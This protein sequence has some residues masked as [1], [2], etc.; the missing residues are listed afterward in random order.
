[1]LVFILLTILSFLNNGI[2]ADYSVERYPLIP[3]PAELVARD[4]F[5]IITPA[6][7]INS[8]IL[9]GETCK[10]VYYLASILSGSLGRPCFLNRGGSS[11]TGNINIVIDNKINIGNEGYELNITPEA[12]KI[13]AQDTAGAFY[14]IQTLRQLLPASIE[15]CMPL[16]K[17]ILK[18]PCGNIKDS[19]RFKYRGLMLDTARH[20]FSV[21]FIKK[22]IDV[23]AAYKFNTF[24]WH[25][26]DD[27]GWRIEIKRYPLLQSI[28]AF[29]KQTIVGHGRYNYPYM[30]D[31][32]RYGGYYSQEEIKEIVAFA[33]ERY[34]TVIPEI[35]FPGHCSAA[36]AAYP[37]IGC[38][39][40]QYET[41][42]RWGIF[43][44]TYCAGNEETFQFAENLLREVMQLFPSTLI[45]IGGDEV[46]K[47]C[48]KNCSL[49]QKRIQQEGLTGEEQLKSYFIKRIEKFLNANGRT[50]IGWDEILEGGLASNATVMSWR[51][52][53]GGIKAANLGHTVIMTPMEYA[54]FDFYQ[55]KETTEPLAIGGYV[56]LSKVYEFEPIPTELSSENVHYILGVQAN[57]WT[58]YI[59]TSEH[60]CYMAFPRACALAEVAWSMPERKSYDFFKRRLQ[61]NLEHL[62]AL[63]INYASY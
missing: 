45:H 27:Q 21:E 49:C 31:R 15:K 36:L 6:T 47:N 30:Y 59:P 7:E 10:L 2:L 48:W 16:A 37:Q 17:P 35:E 34:I 11:D 53:Q 56:P 38:I 13:L 12:I 22:F 39:N 62:K 24:H 33:K 58:E 60:V 40:T 19:P 44:A 61:V 25:L 9:D 55:S 57:L 4:G 50:I 3:Q 18:V 63:A 28:A 5:F 8:N 20:M 26:T 14:A 52:M 51:G 54:Y 43:P 32:K 41:A 1:M 46:Q 42:I 23:L 29:R